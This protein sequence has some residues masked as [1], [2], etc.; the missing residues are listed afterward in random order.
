MDNWSR[1]AGLQLRSNGYTAGQAGSIPFWLH[2]F[3]PEGSF[4]T[5]WVELIK[6]PVLVALNKIDCFRPRL[7]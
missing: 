3:D 7:S 1:L 6:A 5:G 4:A 2:V